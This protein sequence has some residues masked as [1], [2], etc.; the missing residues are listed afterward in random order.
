MV[1]ALRRW[2]CCGRRAARG[3][4]LLAAAGPRGAQIATTAAAGEAPQ[5]GGSALGEWAAYLLVSPTRSSLA[6]AAR[7]AD[8]PRILRLHNGESQEPGPEA[9]RLL[10]P[11]RLAERVDFS[12]AAGAR[13][14][15][16]AI[17]RAS[18]FRARLATLRGAAR[19][20]PEGEGPTDAEDGVEFSNPK[21][22]KS[23]TVVALVDTGSSDCDLR[24]ELIGR[25]GLPRCRAGLPSCFETAAGRIVEAPSY[26][27][28]LRVLGREVDVRVNPTDEDDDEE[29]DEEDRA[30]GLVSSTD[31][32]VL[33][34]QAL[35][36]LGLCVDCAGRRLVE[37]VAGLPAL[38]CDASTAMHAPIELSSGGRSVRVRALVDSGCTDVDLDPR[39]VEALGLHGGAAEGS[40]QFETAGG[41]T[42]EAPVYRVTAS[43]LGRSASVL[44]SPSEAACGG[45]E[46]ESED[47]DGGAA[48]GR[49]GSN[50]DEAL[51]GH[52]ALAALGLFVDCRARRLLAAPRADA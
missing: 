1:L 49:S 48:G 33:G 41:V 46:E 30:M 39:H 23:V 11:W 6:G 2:P 42:I 35:A 3:L 50:Q 5:M 20:A 38:P 40:A 25:L 28:R 34:C 22:G 27:A 24:Q 10:R 51:L 17:A 36:A 44:V 18:G 32:A 47:S 13:H 7:S 14:A 45:D 37:P 9:T 29:E 4:P 8:I 12:D 26:S 16:A 43:A 19:A 15:A 21:S 31:D 52:D